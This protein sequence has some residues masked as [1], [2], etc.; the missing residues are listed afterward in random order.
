MS[1]FL[2]T[3]E[4]SPG[5]TIGIIRENGQV[6]DC[7]VVDPASVLLTPGDRN[8]A[9]L[10]WNAGLSQWLELPAGTPLSANGMIGSSATTMV[11]GTDVA[12][13]QIIGAVGKVG[14]LA[15]EAATLQA[16]SGQIAFSWGASGIAPTLGFYATPPIARPNVTTG[17]LASLQT[18]LND[19][20][21]INLVP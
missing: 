20:G 1:G 14:L 5:Q 4:T 2:Q 6:E 13:L 8:N 16:L 18:A 19:L 9:P 7:A 21:L 11:I 3:I 17:D 12:D 15:F 10:A